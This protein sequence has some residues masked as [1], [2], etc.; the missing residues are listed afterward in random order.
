MS[1]IN[2]IMKDHEC[3]FQFI[4]AINISEKPLYGREDVIIF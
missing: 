3:K 2:S 1:L 4:T